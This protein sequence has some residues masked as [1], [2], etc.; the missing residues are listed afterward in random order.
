MNKFIQNLFQVVY[1]F[2]P[3]WAWFATSILHFPVEKILIF[4]LL[5]ILVYIIW[6][7]RVRVP[8]YLIFFISFTLYHIGSTFYFGLLASNTKPLFFILSDANVL[9][10]ILF[11]VIENTNFDEG[12]L[13]KMNRHILWIV[14]LSLLISIIQMKNPLFFYDTSQDKELEYVGD[15]RIASIYSWVSL[16]SIG[17]TFPILIAILLN[18][19][20]TRSKFFPLVTVSG[21]IVAFLT[22]ARFVMISMI[23]G[24]LQL[25]L[26]SSIPLKK[27][28][29]IIGFFV[30]GIF[31]I[32][33]ASQM[34]GYDI[35]ATINERILEKG[36]D[37]R[38]AKARIVSYDVFMM[39]FPENPY[40]GV[41]PKTRNDVV[42]L[43]DGSAPIIHVGYLSYLYYYGA[44][45]ASL[46]FLALLCLLWDGW[47][48]G[49]RNDFWG[50]F[51]G[52]LG[53]T[54]ANFT[55][56]YLNFS[57]MGII[58]AV[59]YM[60]YYKVNPVRLEGANIKK[61]RKLSYKMA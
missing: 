36:T 58:L 13:R 31:L 29:Y 14:T 49:R 34:V 32:I 59:I 54:L 24:F 52:L 43:L 16:N 28:L 3:L 60:R 42:D 6:V 44:F 1:P 38:S 20:S 9:A 56:V 12:F 7:I 19:Y 10:C 25:L 21:I 5:P 53:F 8:A 11:L 50:S 37:M 45:G 30:V 55:F 15:S 2:Y 35:N 46:L 22:K 18:F 17:V 48:T 23:I 27:K 47:I 51:Y 40:F 61:E 57:E 4:V 33:G 39:K 41:G 26:I